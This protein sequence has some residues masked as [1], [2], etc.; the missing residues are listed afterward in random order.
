MI[1][2]FGEN[3]T[4]CLVYAAARGG[5]VRVGFENNRLHPDG[6]IAINNAERVEDVCQSLRKA[7]HGIAIESEIYEVLGRAEACLLYTSP[8]PRDGLLSRMPSSA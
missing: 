1:C 2:A 5:H 6:R 7:G 4:E 3:E 8:S